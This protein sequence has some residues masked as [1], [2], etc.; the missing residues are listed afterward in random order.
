ML[1]LSTTLLGLL[2]ARVVVWANPVISLFSGV[3]PTVD[4][5]YVF[6]PA[7][8]SSQRL[9]TS[10]V[11]TLSRTN[12]LVKLSTSQTGIPIVGTGTATW[13]VLYSSANPKHAILGTLSDQ[14]TSTAPLLIS[15]TNLVAGATVG[16]LDLGINLTTG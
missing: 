4:L 10:G 14:V 1:R 2:Q 15:T 11:L 6:T 7:N 12:G 3:I 9:A 13:F 16:L 8:Y 5:S